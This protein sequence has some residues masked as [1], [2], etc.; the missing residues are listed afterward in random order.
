V[1]WWRERCLEWCKDKVEPTRYADQKYLD[2]WPELFRGVHIYT[3]PGA[4][5]ARW[6]VKYRKVTQREGR[7]WV[8]DRPLIFFHFASFRQLAPWLY[9]ANFATHWVIPTRLVRQEIFGQYIAELYHV[10]GPVLPRGARLLKL[11]DIG[12]RDLPKLAEQLLR[13]ARSIA[14]LDYIVISDARRHAWRFARATGTASDLTLPREPIPAI[15]FIFAD[16]QGFSGQK[17]ASRLI[18][19]NLP[20]R[21]TEVAL[22]HMPALNR[23]DHILGGLF[24]YLNQTVR[25]VVS[26][27]T[28]ACSDRPVVHLSLGQTRTALLRD[29]IPLF[30]IMGL[31]RRKTAVVSL[32][33]SNFMGWSVGSY[34]ARWLRLIMTQAARLTVLGEGQLANTR[35]LGIPAEKSTI[36]YNTCDAPGLTEPEIADKQSAT[37]GPLRLLHLSSLIDTKGYPAYLEALAILGGRPGRPIEAVLC[38]NITM[39]QY[40]ERFRTK[41]AAEEWILAMVAQINRSGRVQVRWLPGAAGEDKWRLYRTADVFVFPSL[42]KVEA[43]PLVLLEAMTFGCAVVSSEVGEIRS[44]V[45]DRTARLLAEPS[46]VKLAEAITALLAEPAQRREMT[47]RAK[48]VFE[49]RFSKQIYVQTWDRLLQEVVRQPN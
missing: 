49:A 19:E 25:A 20:D 9:Q 11:Q 43:Q 6:N 40:G 26:V 30:L 7:L 17:E 8:D 28:A 3:H 33:G 22:I 4:N 18:Y 1:A 14:L 37:E 27:G 13:I 23:T 44:L 32:H 15:W 41:Q 38:G 5:L 36:V 2:R 16:T 31:R 47:L 46:P 10:A 21:Q 39:S 12:L 42:Y 45:D 24:Y 48:R 29:A 34:E 35:R